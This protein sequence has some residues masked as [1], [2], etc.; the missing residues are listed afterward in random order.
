MRI[1]FAG[2]PDFSVPALQALIESPHEVAAV[3]TQPDRPAGRGRRLTASPV[4]QLALEASIPVHQ[5]ETLRGAAQ[6]RTLGELGADVVVVAAY[7][8]LLPRAILNAPRLGCINIHASLLPRWRGAAPIHRAI[9]A[10]D[11]QT[12]IT[13][14]QMEQGLDSGPMLERVACTIGAQETGGELHDRLAAMGAAAMLSVLERLERGD[15]SGQVQDK[16]LAVYAG[17]IAKEEAELDWG[18][19]AA[20]LHRQVRAFNPW[21]VAQTTLGGKPLRIWRACMVTPPTPGSTPGQVLATGAEGID[22]AT[23]SGLLRIT[24]LQRAGRNRL[25]ADE[26]LNAWPLLGEHLGT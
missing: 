20:L 3:Y 15:A 11:Q 16:D 12:G 23:G 13:I 26:F 25:S 21:P 19:P 10:G 8:L 17:K 18:A 5:P 24:E 2:T 22:V 7:G 1:V 14:M 6:A 4:K 9:L